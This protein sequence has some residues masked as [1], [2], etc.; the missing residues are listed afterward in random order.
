M[1]AVE[2]GITDATL[3]SGSSTDGHANVAIQLSK[4]ELQ[5]QVQ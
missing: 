5:Q 1:V 4:Q 3:I 2:A